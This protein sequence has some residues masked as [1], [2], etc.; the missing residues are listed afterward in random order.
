MAQFHINCLSDIQELKI[1]RYL[2]AILYRFHLLGKHK[3]IKINSQSNSG[4]SN[5]ATG[6][7]NK[8]KSYEKRKKGSKSESTITKMKV[9][10]TERKVL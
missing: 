9:S 4:W 6:E 3:L 1:S 10:F 7:E 5:S 2:T 8:L